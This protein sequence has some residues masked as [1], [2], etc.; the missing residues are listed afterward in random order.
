LFP[1]AAGAGCAGPALPPR[2]P[3]AKPDLLNPPQQKAPRL[4]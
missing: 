3:Q 2:T 4:Y 1:W